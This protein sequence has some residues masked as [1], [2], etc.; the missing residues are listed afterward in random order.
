MKRATITHVAPQPRAASG[1]RMVASEQMSTPKKSSL[2]PP[3]RSA[4]RPLGTF[5][6]T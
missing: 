5:M 4:M 6:A 2:L 3:K 1:M